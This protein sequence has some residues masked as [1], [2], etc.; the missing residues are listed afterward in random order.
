MVLL[1]SNVSTWDGW[2]QE[3]FPRFAHSIPY[4]PAPLQQ[5]SHISNPVKMATDNKYDRQLRLW[6]A[7]GQVRLVD[8]LLDSVTKTISYAL[9][10]QRAIANGHVCLLG[11]SATGCEA[12]KNLV[13]PGLGQYTIIDDGVVTDGDAASNWLLPA[14]DVGQPRAVVCKSAYPRVEFIRLIFPSSFAMTGCL[15]LAA[16]VKS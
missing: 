1:E 2:S 12:L 9:F 5:N 7:D 10:F 4:H 6:G 13:L 3:K 14:T 16:R 8:T 11:A 15:S